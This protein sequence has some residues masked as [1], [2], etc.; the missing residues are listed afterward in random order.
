VQRLLREALVAAG[1]AV[2]QLVLMLLV[3]FFV[4]IWLFWV[5]AVEV[6]VLAAAIAGYAAWRKRRYLVKMSIEE[7]F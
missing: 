4:E 6:A 1:V 5:L 2:L 3:I 7:R